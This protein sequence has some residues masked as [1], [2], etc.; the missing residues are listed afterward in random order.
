MQ[1]PYN[2]VLGGK[3]KKQNEI[4]HS[5]VFTLIKYSSPPLP[6]G[7]CSKT[8]S[9]CLKKQIVPNP[10]YTVFFPIHT[11]IKFNL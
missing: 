1:C 2:T 4:Y 5:L 11:Y 10:I 8:P 9:G 3:K 6:T 7:I